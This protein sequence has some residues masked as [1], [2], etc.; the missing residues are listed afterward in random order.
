MAGKNGSTWKHDWIPTNGAATALKLKKS[1]RS[2]K[3]SGHSFLPLPASFSGPKGHGPAAKPKAPAARKPAASTEK[4]INDAIAKPKAAKP[5]APGLSDG[6]I[7][8]NGATKADVAELSRRYEI[9]HGKPLTDRQL[10]KIKPRK[11]AAKPKPARKNSMSAEDKVRKAYAARTAGEGKPSTYINI[12]DVRHELQAGGMSDATIDATLKGMFGSHA[13][14]LVP[15]ANQ[16]ALTPGIR[17]AGLDIGG[18]RK[19]KISL[20][21]KQLGK[22][23]KKRPVVKAKPLTAW[24]PG[25]EDFGDYDDLWSRT[26]STHTVTPEGGRQETAS[27]GKRWRRN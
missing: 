2:N 23:A 14:N 21:D 24:M 15:A 13:L 12:R 19:H 26:V 11:P 4:R 10:G 9:M 8:G 7:K 20:S 18:D 17:A 3:P 6:Y 5:I 1:S 27:E 25:P 22:F 16:Q